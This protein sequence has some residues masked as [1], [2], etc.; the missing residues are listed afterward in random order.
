MQLDPID[1]RLLRV[2]QAIAENGGFAGA[3]AELGLTTSTLSIHLGNLEKRLGV[4]LCHRGRGGFRL[5]DKGQQLRASL[6]R[7]FLAMEDFRAE[8]GALRDRLSGQLSLGVADNTLSDP[9]APLT[10]AMRRFA[11][12]A[13]EVH[14]SLAVDRPAELTRAL[15]DGRLHAAIGIFPHKVSGLTYSRLYEE[16]HSLYC[17]AGHAMFER[18]D[19]EI[20]P[21]AVAAAALVGRGFDLER[22]LALT[23][24]AAHAA[25]VENMEAQ[26]ILVLSGAYLGFLPEHFAAR[27][28]ETGQMRPVRPAAY[29][30]ILP[31]QLA[32]RADGRRTPVLDAFLGDLFSANNALESFK[33]TP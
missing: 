18:E 2:F 27:W 5:T 24:A 31:M 6:R 21:E 22:D 28:V 3:Q 7:L 19:A 13:P 17:A 10:A 25:T 26:A 20:A 14:V 9:R 33:V 8:A 32:L 29:R 16:A 11:N 4:S 23:G 15:L 30:H 1:L 12:R